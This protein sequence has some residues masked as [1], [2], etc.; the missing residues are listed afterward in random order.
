MS[1]KAAP[2]VPPIHPERRRR[3]RLAALLNPRTLLA[4]TALLVAIDPKIP[5]YKG[6]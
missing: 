3:A 2:A 4:T 1:K 5:P 6:D